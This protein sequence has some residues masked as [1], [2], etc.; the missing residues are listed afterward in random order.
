[1][2]GRVMDGE[3]VPDFGGHFGT[4]GIG[5]RF[6]AMNVEV[7][8]YQVNGFRFRVFHRQA[9]GNLSELEGR[10]VR[11][12][13]CEMAPRFWLYRAENIGRATACVFVIAS[14]FPP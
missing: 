7:V 3:S 1:M 4:E 9:D 5:Q 2:S 8:H 14:R 12:G 11:R 13:K 6:A 10:A